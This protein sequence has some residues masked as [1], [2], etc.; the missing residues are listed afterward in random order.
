[1]SELYFVSISDSLEMLVKMRI[2][3]TLL[4]FVPALVL[5]AVY[6]PTL[7][8][9]PNGSADYY[10]IDVGETQVVLNVW[11]TLHSTGYPLYVMTGSV[12]VTAL[13]AA[14]ISPA[15]APAVISLLWGG[16]ALALIYIL[17]HHLTRRILPAAALTLLF[18]LTRTVW[19]HHV[20]AE[21]YTF[22]LAI[23]ALLL[24]LALWRGD[25]PGR[26]YW[27]ALIG[28]M[29]VAHH[30]GI[31]MVAPA[32]IFA[33]WPLLVGEPRKLPKILF[34]CLLLGLA[35]FLPY[36]Y[37]PLR[38]WADAPWVY[39]EPGTLAGLWDQFMGRE[40]SRF[41]GLAG[42]FD[43]LSA[44]VTLV[45]RVLLTD[46]TL[47][48]IMLGLVGLV[49]GVKSHDHRRAAL[50]LILSGVAAYGFHI[51]FYSDI[52]SALILPVTLSLAFGWIFLIDKVLVEAQRAAPSLGIPAVVIA[53]GIFAAVLINANY[54]FIETLTEDATGLKTIAEA[55]AVPPSAALMLAWG[56]RHF[57]VGF[58]QAVLGELDD[59]QLVDHKADFVT[60]AQTG[61][62]VTPA[63]TF[64]NQ[65]VSWWEAEIGQPVFL[66]A[67]APN[68]VAIRTVPE[69]GEPV[70]RL[71]AIADATICNPDT[72]VLTVD[73]AA[74]DI[75]TEDWSVFVHLLDSNGVVIAQADQSA[76]VYGWR[77]L[78]TWQPGERVRDIYTLPRLA[79]ASAMRYGLYHQLATGEFVNEI[80]HTLLVN[81]DA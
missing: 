81:C 51:A 9:I 35:G 6:L 17:T 2:F 62:L 72:L 65:P 23:L 7:Q 4:I 67:A 76:P 13:R 5:L 40:A 8:T 33:V 11:G 66:S 56:P 31:A 48:G 44:N 18:G 36:L 71:D 78:T 12:G 14:G 29:G 73:W 27:L 58:A 10:M 50:T 49:W 57:A 79:E 74:P 39:G 20:I 80:E 45:N 22:G 61:L 63:Y 21:I 16:V 25:I 77:P 26:V 3:R 68:L 24:I 28:G 32:L 70:E 69:Q 37:L 54:A 75:P 38:A 59:V 19:I 42:S 15:T 43:A 47:P 1:M 52:L 64:Y 55:Q 41:I 53:V 60:L 46:L 30:R 34:F